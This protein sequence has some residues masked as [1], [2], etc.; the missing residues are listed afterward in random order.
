MPYRWTE[1]FIQTSN[2]LDALEFDKSYN[3]YKGL[4]NGNLDRENIPEDSITETHIKKGAF[5]Y[6]YILDD[7]ELDSDYYVEQ[8]GP[9]SAGPD[10]V[11]YQEFS[12][13]WKTD[14]QYLEETFYEGMAHIEFNCWYWLND[15][16]TGFAGT[17]YCEFQILYNN[18]VIA[19]TDRLGSPIGQVHLVADIPVPTGTGKVQ[20]QWRIQSPPSGVA[21]NEELFWYSGGTIFCINRRR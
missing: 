8:T 2:L 5:H 4:I 6:Y 15:N 3:N 21:L 10:G 9:A 12:G 20:L 11:S 13:G 17:E 7:I 1:A 19:R 16:V 18:L 14:Q